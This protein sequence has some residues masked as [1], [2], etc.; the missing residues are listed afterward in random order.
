MLVLLILSIGLLTACAPANPSASTQSVTFVLTATSAEPRPSLPASVRSSLSEQAAQAK[1]A[2]DATV[3]VISSGA[4]AILAKDLAPM[5]G[6]QIEHAP[7]ER[8]RKIVAALDDLARQ[9][10]D[11]TADRPG[12]DLLTLLDRASELPSNNIHVVSSGISTEDPVDMRALGWNFKPAAVVDAVDAQ[13]LL[14]NLSGRHVTFHNL[15]AAAGSQLRLS[16]ASR[17][18][19]TGLW[20][21]MCARAGATCTAVTDA[22][23]MDAPIAKLPVPV[24]PLSTSVTDG[25]CPVWASLSDEVLQFAPRSA[26]LPDDAD[27]TLRPVVEAAR[28]CNVRSIDIAGHVADLGQGNEIGDI[29]GQ[30]ARAVADRLVAL[31]LPKDALGSV[32]GRGNREPV[33]INFTDGQFDESKARFN[34]RCELTY[35]R[36]GSR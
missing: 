6:N 10:A 31:G 19:V 11:V 7:A 23:G 34:R 14:P 18:A 36:A 16:P 29:S 12:L 4:G 32:T 28:R 15:G 21:A 5:R 27:N 3:H 17:D 33:V 25:G 8:D 22:S 13:G 30:R 26:V 1:N 9:I 2:G 35:H 20:L 24:V